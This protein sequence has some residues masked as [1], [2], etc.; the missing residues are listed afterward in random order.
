MSNLYDL[1]GDRIM[2]TFSV[3]YYYFYYHSDV[4][5]ST[6]HIF[7]DLTFSLGKV[8]KVVSVGVYK[9]YEICK[10][11]NRAVSH[12]LMHMATQYVSVMLDHNPS[13]CEV[14]MRAW[15]SPNLLASRGLHSF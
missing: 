9:F 15:I 11:M 2:G 4:L 6:Q 1:L 10:S 7:D 8:D 3:Q 13:N 12:S 14:S 5:D